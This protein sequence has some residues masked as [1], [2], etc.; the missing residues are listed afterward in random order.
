[1]RRSLI[2][3]KGTEEK[4]DAAKILSG[5]TTSHLNARPGFDQSPELSL[6]GSHRNLGESQGMAMTSSPIQTGKP[7]FHF[8]FPYDIKLL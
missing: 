5:S 4:R 7:P 8:A 2:R 6:D 1:M 3:D